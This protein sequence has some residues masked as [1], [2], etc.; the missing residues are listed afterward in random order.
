MERK[1]PKKDAAPKAEQPAGGMSARLLAGVR[2]RLGK[3][4]RR[5]RLAVLFGGLTV[6]ANLILVVGWLHYKAAKSNG[7]A[8]KEDYLGRAWAALDRGAY[9]EAKRQ[10]HLARNSDL[11]DEQASSPAFILGAA[12]AMQADTL[13]EEDQRRYY[14]V[15][16]HYLE[17]S[18]RMGFPLDREGQGLFLLGK[19]LCLSRQYNA[20]RKVLEEALAG[21]PDDARELHWLAAV[22]YQNGSPSVLKKAMAQIDQYLADKGLS[23]A[24][25]DQGLLAKGQIL[26][27]SGRKEACLALLEKIPPDSAS[28]TDAI[29]LRGQLLKQAAEK[30]K[31]A[32]PAGATADARRAV[33]KQFRDA[34]A[35]LRKAQNRGSSAER[36]VPQSMYLIGECFLSMNDNHAALD[37]FRRIRK[38]Y[39]DS[40]EGVA[41][42]F[43]EADLLRRFDQDTDATAAY[44]RAV[45]AVGDPAEYHNSI[46]SLDDLRVRL[47]EAYQA[48]LKSGKYQQAIDLASTTFPLFPRERQVELIAQA[49]EAWASLLGDQ[50]EHAAGVEGREIARHARAELRQAGGA[51]AQLA[52]LQLATRTY[53]ED[54]WNSAEC[55]LAG[56]DFR[57]TVRMLDEYLRY[58]LRHR[59]PRALLNLGE[60][61]LSLRRYDRALDALGE[62]IA[63]YPSDSAA[64]RARLL[65]A[66]A[67][68]DK[69][70]MKEAERLLLANLDDGYLTPKSFEWRD[71]LFAYGNLLQS[72]GRDAEAIP[73]LEEFVERYPDSPNQIEA[74][75]LVAE[76]YRRSAKVPREKLETDAIETSRIDHAKEMQQLLSAA[77]EQ[78]EKVEEL[79]NLRQEQRQLDTLEQSILRNCYFAR[80]STLFEMGRFE[81]AIHAYS[82]ATNHYQRQPI[83]LEALMQIAACYRRLGKPDEARNTMAQAKVMLERI[84]PGAKFADTTL[85]NRDEWSRV[86]NWYANL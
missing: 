10:A 24:E 53:T 3:V 76:A 58:E 69:G 41:S 7:P 56:H 28:F 2:A 12:E 4:S 81:D 66:K 32:L 68:I 62:C 78:Y 38:G 34:I 16:S 75:Y 72:E 14:L 37:Q 40:I 84:S 86:L 19:S 82:A 42:A 36:V 22:A 57:G 17:E 83:V 30:A 65:A 46:L 60:A 35:T 11:T 59:R 85:Y 70:N 71:S 44:R 64:Y 45:E 51:Y 61:E 50:A 49:H 73:K 74:R 63:V 9:F 18:H 54:V 52:E 55:L 5:T 20:S 1:Q 23:P 33:E 27:K 26:F 6:A 48:Y 31:A 77:L 80:G 13:W 29:V 47:A 79:L 15:A 43:Q 21:D 67:Q 25:R 8:A 39:P